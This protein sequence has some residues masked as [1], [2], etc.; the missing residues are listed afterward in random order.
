MTTSGNCLSHT[1]VESFVLSR[2]DTQSAWISRPRDKPIE[3]SIEDWSKGH[4]LQINEIHPT[5]RFD[6]SGDG[7]AMVCTLVHTVV[8]QLY[9]GY[10]QQHMAKPGKLP[11]W[12]RSI[13]CTE[14]VDENTGQAVFVMAGM[15]G[16]PEGAPLSREDN[17]PAP[18]PLLSPD[19]VLIQYG[20][21][22]KPYERN[23]E[24]D[25]ES[26]VVV[27]GKEEI[28]LPLNR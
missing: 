14:A 9:D 7:L 4:P 23:Y 8:Y 6:V 17:E 3:R 18:Q 10:S 24:E 15:F 19:F 22:F 25:R 28:P 13:P 1:F 27:G 16:V 2:V 21:L 12:A 5:C 26:G 20:E 11:L